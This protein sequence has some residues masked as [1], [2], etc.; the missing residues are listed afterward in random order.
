MSVNEITPVR[1]KS[2]FAVITI[3]F[4]VDYKWFRA[5]YLIDNNQGNFGKAVLDILIVIGHYSFYSFSDKF[6]KRFGM[7]KSK[8]KSERLRASGT[9]NRSA[10]K[11]KDTLFSS[12][13]FFDPN[14][15]AQ[16]K[17]EMV[18]RVTQ[19]KVPVAKAVSQFGF[20]RPSFYAAKEALDEFGMTGLI[21]KKT[22]PQQG[23]KLNDEVVEYVLQQLSEDNMLNTATLLQRVESKF[24]IKVHPRTLER[25]IARKKNSKNSP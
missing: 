19:D 9:F 6:F 14:D 24:G 17:Y 5:M 3:Q 22:G 2:N 21:H 1:R 20:S 10:D 4:N 25:A 12:S 11:V 18:R 16:V 13:D 23:H 7:T 8:D 15:L